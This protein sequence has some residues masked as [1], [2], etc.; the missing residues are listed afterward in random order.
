MADLPYGKVRFLHTDIEGRT[1]ACER[2][3]TATWAAVDPPLALR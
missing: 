2:D 3:G 1:A